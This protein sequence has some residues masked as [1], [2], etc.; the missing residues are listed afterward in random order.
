M[1]AHNFD[2][3]IYVAADVER[4]L[5]VGVMAQLPDFG[6]VS[7]PAGE[8]YVLRLA[9]ALEHACQLGSLKSCIF[10][11]VTAGAGVTT[12]A[13]RVTGM[14]EAMGQAT[15]LVDAG[16]SAPELPVSEY[17][18]HSE[19]LAETHSAEILKQTTA[20]ADPESI[21]LADTAPLLVSA[22]TEY[23]ARFVDTAIIIIESG[24][25][26]RAQLREVSRTLRRLQITAAG[27]VLNRISIR[28]ADPAFRQSVQ[29]VERHLRSQGRTQTRSSTRTRTSS[30]PHKATPAA[31]PPNSTADRGTA[32]EPS[33]T[34]QPIAVAGTVASSAA[35]GSASPIS[36][37][38]RAPG[39]ASPA[40]ARPRRASPIRGC[41]AGL[42]PAP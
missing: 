7:E 26:T 10:T 27:F 14:L 42:R 16:G 1:G 41:A 33:R 28:N 38:F 32:P 18:I 35:Q 15:V 13:T 9:G 20:E 34:M 21:V 37:T 22:E 6:Q 4:V 29:G 12:L 36:A 31:P 30:R 17:G 24:V 40:V 5:G 19:D 2:P 11:G 39:P 23:L 25:S 3:R 8:E